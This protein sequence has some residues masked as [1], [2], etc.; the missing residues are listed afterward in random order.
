MSVPTITYISPAQAVHEEHEHCWC[1]PAVAMLCFIC[2]ATGK[3]CDPTTAEYVRCEVCDGRGLLP[4]P[5]DCDDDTPKVIIH[6]GE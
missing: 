5:E 6:R 4:L 1:K 2:S 3:I